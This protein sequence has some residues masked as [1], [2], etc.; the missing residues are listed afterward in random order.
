MLHH[1]VKEIDY[2]RDTM[3]VEVRYHLGWPVYDPR[4][5]PARRVP[6]V[7]RTAD[8][9]MRPAASRPAQNQARP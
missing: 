7:R 3:V 4:F 5:G 6:V 2:V 9:P 8:H 1:E